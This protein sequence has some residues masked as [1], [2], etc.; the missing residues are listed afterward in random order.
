M[1]VKDFEEDDTQN[2]VGFQPMYKYFIK[3]GNTESIWP[4][5]SKRLSN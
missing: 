2:Y 3:I 4:W 1:M 5:G